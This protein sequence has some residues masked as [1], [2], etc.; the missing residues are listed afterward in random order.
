[1][2][3]IKFNHLNVRAF[4]TVPIWRIESGIL[5]ARSPKFIINSSKCKFAYLFAQHNSDLVS[6]KGINNT[7]FL[8][9]IHYLQNIA[10]CCWLHLE[11]EIF[12]WFLLIMWSGIF[13]LKFKKRLLQMLTLYNLKCSET[14]NQILFCLIIS[15][16][17]SKQNC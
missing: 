3:N 6:N 17:F 16:R 9:V 12:F 13:Q 5:F 15:F 10:Y 4:P 8:L 11:K 7:K 14:I 2:E 1:M